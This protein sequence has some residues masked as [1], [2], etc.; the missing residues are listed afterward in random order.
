MLLTSIYI[1]LSTH[2]LF[3]KER[4]KVPVQEQIIKKRK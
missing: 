3:I 1:N 2:E 4:K